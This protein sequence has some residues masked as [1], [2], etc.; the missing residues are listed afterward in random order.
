MTRHWRINSIF[1][2][3]FKNSGLRA[4]EEFIPKNIFTYHNLV[5]YRQSIIC[6]QF[7]VLEMN[8][9]FVKYISIALEHIYRFPIP[10]ISYRHT[11]TIANLNFLHIIHTSRHHHHHHHHRHHHRHLLLLLSTHAYVHPMLDFNIELYIHYFQ[12]F[13]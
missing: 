13:I 9:K 3:F 10:L 1:G 11:I 6:P 4:L 8:L 12:T 5:L 2:K 7:T